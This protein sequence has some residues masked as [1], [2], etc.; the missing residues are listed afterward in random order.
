MNYRLDRG[1]QNPDPAEV[2]SGRSGGRRFPACG[3]D[4]SPHRA[5]PARQPEH[6]SHPDSSLAGSLRYAPRCRTDRSTGQI[7]LNE[8][9]VGGTT[10]NIRDCR[11]ASISVRNIG[12]SRKQMRMA[13]V[14]GI[15]LGL[16]GGALQAEW[17]QQ[18]TQASS[19]GVGQSPKS[20]SSVS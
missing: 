9:S 20:S 18:P 10:L 8:E 16:T 15:A 17:L 3:P 6:G 11:Q 14:L 7:P 19:P 4:S 2:H 12:T 13:A 1:P 5:R